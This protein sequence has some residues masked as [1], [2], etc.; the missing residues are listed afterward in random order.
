MLSE[1]LTVIVA[2]DVEQFVCSAVL[3]FGLMHTHHQNVTLLIGSSCYAQILRALAN[4]AHK[5]KEFCVQLAHLGLLSALCATL[6][7]ADQEMVTL[8]MDVLF[9]LVV[10]GPQVN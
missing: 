7:M 3:I 6:K 2:L 10:S 8:S 4:I 1:Y 5:K 9:M